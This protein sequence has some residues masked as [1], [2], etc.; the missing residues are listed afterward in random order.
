MGLG[1]STRRDRY[2]ARDD[3]LA[4]REDWIGRTGEEW[5]KRSAA[6]ERLLGPAGA[7]GLGALGARSGDVVLDLGCGGGVSTETLGS[8][9]APGGFVT[10]I[11]VSPDLVAQARERTAGSDHVDVIEADAETYQFSRTYDAVYSRFGSMFFDDPS[12]AMKNVV[13]VLR[14]GA[15]AVFVTWREAA[16][17]QWASVP[18]TFIAQGAV[19]PGPNPGPGP[20]GWANPNVFRT[21]LRAAGL[22]DVRESSFEYMAEIAEGDDPNPLI[23][24]IRFMTRLGPL[25]QRLRDA[26]DGARLEAEQFLAERLQRHVHQD[27]VRLLASA[28]IIEA[29]KPL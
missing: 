17:N 9:V 18:M 11:D 21:L 13:S 27:A 24:A 4:T 15:R 10:G 2:Q 7:A 1:F 12:A 5:A 19:T 20:F 14:P 29:R 25:A 16:R 6:L 22:E 26:P 3:D 8:S 23:R 28:W